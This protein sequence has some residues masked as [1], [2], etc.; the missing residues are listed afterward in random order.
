MW[1]LPDGR[2][3]GLV[4]MGRTML[5]KSLIPFFWWVGA[6][7]L[8]GWG[9]TMGSPSKRF[10]PA[11]LY[12]VSLTLWQATS[13]P[14]LCRRFLNTHRQV[15]LSLFWG[16]CSFLLGLGVHKV[17]F[18]PSKSLFPQLCGNS[19]VKS[20]WPP[21]SNCLGFFSPFAGSPGWEICCG[22]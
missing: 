21:Q 5:S 20:H 10:M 17:S 15:W 7:L 14:R 22:S 12:S 4:L 2:N 3:L 8:M 13:D 16:H 18:L 19:I 11:L 1:K 9:Q 6:H